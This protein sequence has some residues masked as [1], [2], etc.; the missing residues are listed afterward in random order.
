M[1]RKILPVSAKMKTSPSV[2][3]LLDK[4]P[5]SLFWAERSQSEI[6]SST[7]LRVLSMSAGNAWSRSSFTSLSDEKVAQKRIAVDMLLEVIAF[8]ESRKVDVGARHLVTSESELRELLIPRRP[9]TTIRVCRMS[10]R[11]Q[12]F[13]EADPLSSMEIQPQLEVD[14]GIVGRWMR[15]LVAHKVGKNTLIAAL[16]CLS[17]LSELLAFEYNGDNK[18]LRNLS[19]RYAEGHEHEVNQAT[20]YSVKWLQ[21]AESMVLGQFPASKPDRLVC[22]R[23]RIM[24]QSSTRHHDLK[25]SPL[26]LVNWVLNKDSSKRAAVGQCTETKTFARTWVCSRLAVA[27]SNDGWLEATISLAL[28]AHSLTRGNDDHFGKR[29]SMD[30]LNWDVGPPS[31]QADTNHVRFLMLKARGDKGER[32]FSDIEVV[33]FRHHGAKCTLPTLAQYLGLNRK[34]VRDQ[35][36]WKGVA[37]DLMPDRYMRQKQ[38]LALDLQ[39]RCLA[40]LRTGGEMPKVNVCPVVQDS[41]P[42]IEAPPLESS[43]LDEGC[44]V[45]HNWAQEEQPVA[46]A[47]AENSSSEA[48][49]ES[50]SA[51]SLISESEKFVGD[52]LVG[53]CRSGK[54]HRADEDHPDLP[55]CHAGK[56]HYVSIK[57]DDFTRWRESRPSSACNNPN[58]FSR[59]VHLD[60]PVCEHICG[61]I[62]EGLICFRRC[63]EAHFTGSPFH[64]CWEH[65][66]KKPKLDDTE[67][68]D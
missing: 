27:E 37:E 62:R 3:E 38:V 59:P 68:L 10:R 51:T 2:E 26:R 19:S 39:E 21:W 57:V 14:A 8:L 64:D 58:C 23:M 40:H 36:G 61:H 50:D 25:N 63:K 67:S 55:A 60:E 13:V 33:A 16:G 12:K 44:E 31:G 45:S 41:H 65:G 46:A 6:G 42:S 9:G 15:D 24:A 29:A 30:R 66:S 34:A 52:C 49:Q 5:E 53:N 4:F 48:E 1:R 17:H 35:G 11:F 56:L 22:G 20:E 28:E 54:Y 18:L 43:D 7:S 32:T 47:A